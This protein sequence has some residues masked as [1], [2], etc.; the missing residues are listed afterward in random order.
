MCTKHCF[1][2]VQWGIHFARNFNAE[3]FVNH[4][5]HDPFGLEG[6]NLPISSAKAIEDEYSKMLQKEKDALR[7]YIE[8]ENTDGLSIE[9]SIVEGEPVNEISKFIKEKQIDLLIM[10]AHEQGHIEHFLSGHEI[11]EL[12]RRMPCSVFLVRRELEYQ[13]V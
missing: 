11:R 7:H 10:T 5:M 6:W 3:L 4:I 13:P 8:T 9:E 2:A 1:N 12:V